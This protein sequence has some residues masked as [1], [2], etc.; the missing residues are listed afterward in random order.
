[1]IH[2]EA[3]PLIPAENGRDLARR[4]TNATSDFIAGMGHDLPLQLVPRYA[5]GI[6]ANAARGA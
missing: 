2:G 3:D 6:A 4:I 5:D 1:V